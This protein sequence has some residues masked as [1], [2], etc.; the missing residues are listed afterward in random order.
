MQRSPRT[1]DHRRSCGLGP[2]KNGEPLKDF[3]QVFPKDVGR[4]QNGSVLEEISR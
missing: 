2:K 4:S 1:V 3:N